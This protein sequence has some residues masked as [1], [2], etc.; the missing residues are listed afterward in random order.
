MKINDEILKIKLKKSINVPL[1]VVCLLIGFNTTAQNKEKKN[2]RGLY[3][4]D[5][6][7]LEKMEVETIFELLTNLNYSGIVVNGRGE[8]ALKRLD[9]YLELS[10]KNGENFKVYAAY[11]AHRF[12]KY[13]FTDKDH[14]AAIDHVEGK[15]IA[16]WVWCK[17]RKQ[18]GSVTDEKVEHWIKGIVE[19]A[20]SKKVK[21]ILYSHYG[22]Y[23]PT[24]LDA[25][26]LVEK[27]NSPF[28]GLS[29]NLTHELRSDKGPILKKTFKKSKKYI[30]TIILAGSIIELDR[31]SPDTMNSSTVMSL[32]KSEYDLIPFMKLTKK[33]G[34]DVPLG[35]VNFK[36][37][38]DP[39]VYLKNTMD[40]WI[41]MCNEVGLYEE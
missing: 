32:E 38:D 37:K 26:K 17:D 2:V 4:Y 5:F 9:R 3:T 6:G 25:L 18:D 31:T 20:A 29:I 21:V 13:G 14:R 30:S 1:V 22:T 39:N 19:Y 24:T 7:G 34:S 35:F 41:E 15:G 27:I 33:Y 12:D 8:S 28:L 23:F 10:E 40:R 36:I 11:L 16:I